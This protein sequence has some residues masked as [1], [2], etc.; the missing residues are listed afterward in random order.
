MGTRLF[1][2]YL[3]CWV[4][5]WFCFLGFGF[6]WCGLLRLCVLM[7]CL[8]FKLRFEFVLWLFYGNDVWVVVISLVYYFRVLWF[9]V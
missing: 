7:W 8:H 3:G 4:N 6:D 2:D 5:G 9:V 1:F